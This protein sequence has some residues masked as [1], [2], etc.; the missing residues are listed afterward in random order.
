MALPSPSRVGPMGLFYPY[1]LAGRPPAGSRHSPLPP[2]QLAHEHIVGRVQ[3]A[4]TIT[5]ALLLSGVVHEAV[6][7]VLQHLAAPDF[8]HGRQVRADRRPECIVVIL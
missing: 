3:A 8:F 2:V 4:E 7:V 6:G 5:G 1:L